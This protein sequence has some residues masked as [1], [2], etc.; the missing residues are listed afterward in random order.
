[1]SPQY[2]ELR[3]TIAAEI[4]S[5]VWAAL[6][7]STVFASWQR[8]CTACGSGRVE[9][10]LK[11]AGRVGSRSGFY[12]SGW[13]GSHNLDPRATLGPSSP[14]R[15][16]WFLLLSIFSSPQP[17]HTGRP[18]YFHTWCGLSAFL[19]SISVFIFSFLH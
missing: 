2:F 19:L 14:P 8:Y 7:I 11:L 17:S 18:P 5:L 15:S 16:L 12:G 4:A 1:M 9:K 13:V 10:K 6:Q 3:P